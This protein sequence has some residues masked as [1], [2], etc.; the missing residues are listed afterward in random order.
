MDINTLFPINLPKVKSWFAIGT[1]FEE[2]SAADVRAFMAM[3][4]VSVVSGTAYTFAGSDAGSY[5]RFTNGSAITATVPN[6]SAVPVPIGSA[7]AFEQEGAGTITVS[8]AAGVTV[9]SL[10]SKVNSS[11]Q[12]AVLELVKK[13]TNTW[14]LF[15]SLA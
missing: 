5:M 12:F 9:N 7:I 15:G 10:S 11:G 13:D 14:T 6:N 4:P 3:S 8:G 2:C 1:G